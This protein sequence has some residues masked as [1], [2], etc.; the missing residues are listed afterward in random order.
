MFIVS[1]R[2]DLDT[3]LF[4]FPEPYALKLRLKDLLEDCVD[5]KYYLSD[6]MM[7]Y[8]LGVNQKESKFPRR[9]RF[10]SNINRPNQDVANCIST[11]AGSR[12]VDNFIKTKNG[13]YTDEPYVVDEEPDIMVVGKTKS[14]GERSLVLDEEGICNCLTATDYK[15]PK[16]ILVRENMVTD[17]KCVQVGTLSGGKW[18]KINES[19]RRVYSEDGIAPTIHTCQGGNTEPKI[20]VREATK[21]GFAEAYEGDSVNLAYPESTTRRGRVGKQVSQTLQCNDNMGV[22]VAAAMCGRYSEDG[23][24]HQ[25]IEVSDREYANTIT[26]VQKDSLIAEPNVLTPK[27]TEYGKAIRKAYEGGEIKESRHNMTELVPRTDGIA[28]TITTVQKDNYLVEPTL[29]IRKLTPRECWRLQG[30]DDEDVDKCIA[31]GISNA[32][33]YKQAGNSITVDVAEELLCMLFDEEGDF[34]V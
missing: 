28:N 32:Q 22:V 16:Q 6:A 25:N 4:E 23:T 29:R 17:P 30:F 7:D 34:Y 31:G 20:L 21:K 13:V 2:K 12:P 11:N 24:V 27:R 9:E 26:T 33:L 14:G 8:C 5:E 1:I 18:D 10:L 15:Q 19:C 3:G